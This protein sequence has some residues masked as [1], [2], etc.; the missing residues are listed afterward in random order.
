[1]KEIFC[2]IGFNTFIQI[3]G[4]VFSVIL[5]LITV[6]L[7]TRYLGQEGFGNFSLAFAYF[8]IFGIIADWGLQL[9]MVRELAKKE[10][11]PKEIYGTYFW[12]K[13]IMVTASTL[14]AIICLL[15]FPYSK[16]LKTGIILAS[17]GA[18]VGVLNTYGTVILQANLRLDLV[19]LVEVLTKIITT[20]FI[21]IFV[22]LKLGLYS[23]INTI[24]IGNLGGTLLIVIILRKLEYLNFNF[25]LNFMEQII[26]KCLPVGFI[27]LF[28]LVNF[29]LDTLLLSILK[30][31]KE[32]G[33]YSLAYRI[34]ENL[35][36]FWGFYIGSVYPLLAR[37]FN[38]DQKIK[39]EILW[40]KS[41]RLAILT[42]FIISFFGYF[43]A[44]LIISILGGEEFVSSVLPLRI[45]LFSIPWFF[46][47]NLY[48]HN[49]LV[50]EKI[51]ALLLIC[52]FSIFINFFSNLILIPPLSYIGSAL[53][54]LGTAIFSW[55][56]YLFFNS[57]HDKKRYVKS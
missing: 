31:P 21:V 17:L 3:L 4:K 23:I 16:F 35:L 34:V 54:M 12:L 53:G 36:V 19:T 51:K 47:N 42:G 5:G 20:I 56:I 13:L 38:K 55:L 6:G 45:L 2:R 18:A 32:V 30:D 57:Q 7:L 50:K 39:M 48:F 24:L 25:K 1:M 37:F 14:L 9:T 15:F 40:K 52:S 46:L 33:I 49:F 41:L 27:S 22:S 29:K 44:P 8:S 28:S 11:L 26:K 10:N 43:F